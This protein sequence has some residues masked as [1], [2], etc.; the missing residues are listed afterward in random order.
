VGNH[1]SG[2]Q[3]V[4][5]LKKILANTPQWLMITRSEWTFLPWAL[6]NCF[7][8]LESETDPTLTALSDLLNEDPRI[9]ILTANPKKYYTNNAV[10]LS[11][12]SFHGRSSDTIIHKIQKENKWTTP[13][14]IMISRVRPMYGS[15][16]EF[17]DHYRSLLADYAPTHVILDD[18]ISIDNEFS[19]L[20]P[21]VYTEMEIKKFYEQLK[22]LNGLHY[23][24][25]FIT[26]DHFLFI[27]SDQMDKDSFLFNYKLRALS[28]IQCSLEVKAHRDTRV[29]LEVEYSTSRG[30]MNSQ[31]IGKFKVYAYHT[32]LLKLT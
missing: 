11:I 3:T 14:E 20:E 15:L 2:V 22:D 10:D 6:F 18:K 24:Q 13:T 16:Q 25:K 8:A 30:F 1:L 29:D 19:E 9:L 23:I 31:R 27:P 17:I 21:K 12:E 5:D 32:G 7:G 4:D 28:D 26:H